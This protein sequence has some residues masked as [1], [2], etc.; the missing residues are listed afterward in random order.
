MIYR[1]GRKVLAPLP[2]EPENIRNAEETRHAHE[3]GRIESTEE[4][5][6]A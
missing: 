5:E 1:N 4:Q 2:E 6:A 3:S